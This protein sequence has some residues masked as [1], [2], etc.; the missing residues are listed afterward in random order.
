M[1]VP[2]YF[3]NIQNVRHLRI[4]RISSIFPIWQ[5]GGGQ[6]IGMAPGS[7]PPNPSRLYP[8]SFSRIISVRSSCVYRVIE[9][10]WFAGRRVYGVS[11]DATTR[12]VLQESRAPTYCDYN[13]EVMKIDE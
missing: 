9:F 6:V 1:F 8:E 5:G 2:K 12:E 3:N 13:C 7:S 11:A 4:R 10:D